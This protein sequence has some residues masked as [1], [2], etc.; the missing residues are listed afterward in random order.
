ME[1]NRI[2]LIEL[3]DKS[4][5]YIVAVIFSIFLAYLIDNA[6]SIGGRIFFVIAIV[7]SV[8][9][10]F[11]I[12][13]FNK[14]VQV[15]NIKA[16]ILKIIF[17]I[18]IILSIIM[19][20]CNFNFFTK[21][22]KKS[23][24]KLIQ[25]EEKN[26]YSLGNQVTVT[27]I[28]Q[29]NKVQDVFDGKI[30]GNWVWDDYSNTKISAQN[31]GSKF[32]RVLF[33]KSNDIRITFEKNENS[34]KVKI[35][36]G[37]Y[38]SII[39]LYS[40]K[41]DTYSYEVK[42]NC[43]I[44]ILFV[45]RLIFSFAM[46]LFVTLLVLI[47][48][49]YLYKTQKSIILPTL[50]LI[51]LLRGFYYSNLKAYTL[52]PDSESYIE[53]DF[54]KLLNLEIPARTPIYPLV[55]KM[56]QTIFGMELF[57]EFVVLFQMLVSF[58]AVIYFYKL[59][60]LMIK[61]EGVIAF[62]TL[63][64]GTTNAIWGWDHSILTE[65]LA[66]S[67]YVFFLYNIIKYIKGANLFN[68]IWAVIISIILTFLR[69]TSIILTVLLFAFWIGRFIFDRKEIKTD[70]KCFLGSLLSLVLIIVYSI[71]FYQT[72]QIYSISDPTIRQNLF[73]CIDQGFYKSSDNRQFIEDIEAEKEA[74]KDNPY[75][76]SSNLKVWKVE[77]IIQEKYGNKKVQELTA[78]CVKQNIPQ[79][80]EYVINLIKDSSTTQ[81]YGYSAML[82]DYDS[83][84]YDIQ[85][86]ITKIANFSYIY[87][88]IIMEL[89]ITLYKWIKEKI[90]PWL[91]IG[92]FG[93]SFAIM[94]STFIGTNAE[95]MRT[96]IGVLPF[97]YMALAMLI[98]Y[99][100]LKAQKSREIS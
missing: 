91:H 23:E 13:L 54:S 10:S 25:L 67:G 94:L 34:G 64:Y 49:Y 17:V 73:I 27:S 52:Y 84:M 20:I 66:L 56:C 68:G 46:L 100:L 80:I 30:Y 89:I 44:D 60:K 45:I 35:V 38:E 32:L 72:H 86:L 65:S 85:V 1:E 71:I 9:S 3:E 6:Y 4:L 19:L 79:Y 59:L 99:I 90:V 82:P 48:S 21:K 88:L 77:E 81:Y 63:I 61:K 37:E 96:S 18:S 12:F 98:D 97:F 69:P 16:K 74:V 8:I 55:I 28:V 58:I 50:V 43:Y 2:S 5:L 40:Y 53:Y 75:Y 11:L 39:D 42:S 93:F 31:G 51:L 22:F 7:L 15:K 14:N 83:V 24:V 87:F 78:Y 29:G 41:T 33:D 62:I 70:F 26:E 95:F 47:A 36:D 57:R 76:S 92:I